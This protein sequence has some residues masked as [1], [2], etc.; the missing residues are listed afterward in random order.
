MREIEATHESVRMLTRQK[1][2]GK[3]GEAFGRKSRSKEKNESEDSPVES[4]LT[5][6]GGDEI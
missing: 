1:E 4:T 3:Q 2:G 5:G 6:C